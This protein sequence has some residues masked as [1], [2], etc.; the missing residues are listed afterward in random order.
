MF[1]DILKKVMDMKWKTKDNM[2]ARINISLF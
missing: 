2:K 1:G